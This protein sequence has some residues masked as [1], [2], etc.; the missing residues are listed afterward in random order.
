LRVLVLEGEGAMNNLEMKV[1]APLVIEIRDDN[2]KPVENAEVTFQLPAT[3]PGGFFPG[4]QTT[5]VVKTNLQG[6]ALASGFASN[7]QTG[8]FTIHVKAVSGDR[9]G[10][11]DV[12]Q[13]NALR[14]TEADLHPKTGLRRFGW[15]KI[16]LIAAAATA[17]IVTIVLVKGGGSSQGSGS[18]TITI[19]P[20]PVTVSG[21]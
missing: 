2:D 18:Q 20:G 21:R 15:W 10:E 11:A 14:I 8:R 9:F 17:T 13:I 16:G 5:K 1:Y 3:G 7:Q 19:I 12:S 4:N 6:Q